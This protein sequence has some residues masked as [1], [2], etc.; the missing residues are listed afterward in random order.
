MSENVKKFP[1]IILS[2]LLAVAFWLYVDTLLKSTV[3]ETFYDVPVEFIGAEDTLPNRGLMLSDGQD[4]TVNFT[5]SGPRQ[6]ITN[7]RSGDMRVQV[8]LSSITAVGT[9]PLP[10]NLILPDNVDQSSINQEK[11]SRYY[12]TVQVS[13][14][15]S[16]EVS[17]SVDVTPP[18]SD[19]Y[20]YMGSDRLT[21]EPSAVTL[22]GLVDDV[23]QVES[24]RVSVDL[25]SATGTVSQEFSYEFLDAEGNVVDNDRIR[26]SDRR[27]VV[28]APV[29]MIKELPLTVQLKE[30]AGSREKN[31]NWSLE[32]TSITVAGDPVSLESINEI[33]LGEVDLSNYV[34]DTEIDL[35]IKL[36]AGCD[37]LSGD[38][39]HTT[40]TLKYHGLETR[41][42][43]V[44]NVSSIGLSEGQHFDRI[45]TVVN[46][47]L[48]GPAEDLAL[49]TADDIRI[50]VDVS[51]ITATGTYRASGK[52]LVDGYS[53]VG[54]VGGCTVAFKITS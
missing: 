1:Y 24:C 27:V 7:L 44:T 21:V 36:P 53:E 25:S 11:A 54:A 5:L 23:D 15:Y 4:A 13:T 3:S 50:V 2:L 34:G 46:V 51:E 49:V 38:I 28:T 31:V 9:Y 33:M 39:D 12:V 10:Y 41:S 17:V 18:T 26:V 29:Y 6:V 32:H 8:N 20:M 22:S 42:F 52:V 47:Q 35:Q 43:A 40:L 37:N 14:L 16:R 45:T 19:D 30:S 48:R